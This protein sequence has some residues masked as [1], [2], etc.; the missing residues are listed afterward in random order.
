MRLADFFPRDPR[1]AEAMMKK[2]KVKQAHSTEAKAEGEAKRRREDSPIAECCCTR[3]SAASGPYPQSLP[4]Y[5]T[6]PWT[7][8]S[9]LPFILPWSSRTAAVDY[10]ASYTGT[11]EGALWASGQRRSCRC[12]V[13]SPLHS[14][15]SCAVHLSHCR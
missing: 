4:S 14:I 9:L 3:H 1:K 13:L 2:S 5:T 8:G 10:L 11:R 12:R 7:T 6:R 15:R